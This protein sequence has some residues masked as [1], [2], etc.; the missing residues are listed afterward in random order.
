MYNVGM[1]N[2]L[3]TENS[4]IFKNDFCD[5]KTGEL[6][7]PIVTENFTLI[8]VAE[9]YYNNA[10]SIDSHVQRCDLELTFPTTNGLFCQT[11]NKIEKVGKYQVYLSFRGDNH[12][13]F[14]RNG[15]RFQAVAINF[16]NE[17]SK[18]LL[19]AIINN[20]SNERLLFLPDLSR[21]FSAIINEFLQEEN[22]FFSYNLDAQII[23]ILVKLAR[24][25]KSLKPENF[26]Q[27]LTPADLINYLDLH[28]LD[29]CSLDEL[30]L[31]FGYSYAYISKIFKNAYNQTPQDY[32]ADKKMEHAKMLLKNGKTL[33]EI[34]ETTGYSSPYNF[35]R[36]YKKRFGESPKGTRNS[37]N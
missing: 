2:Y 18:K 29:I 10:F 25:E 31:K 23:S 6:L 4:V 15:C 16:S 13:L 26:L 36:A 1:K 14:S 34:A 30:S 11:D 5:W 21:N 37:P 12:S 27:K 33:S 3:K 22:E 35:S 8:Q 19:S 9:L 17:Y 28:Y 20:H 32:L 7:S 24:N